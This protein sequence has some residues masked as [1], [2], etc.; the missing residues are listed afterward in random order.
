M[1]R[2][3][4]L[5]GAA[6]LPLIAAAAKFNERTAIAAEPR[7]RASVTIDPEREIGRINAWLYGQFIEQTERIVYGGVFDPGSRFADSEG[8]RTDVIDAMKKMGGA[9]ILR[10]PGGNFAS[11]YRWKDGIG[12][13]DKRPRKFDVTG[14]KYETNQFGT[15]EYLSLCQKL[16]CDRGIL[17]AGGIRAEG[18]TV[19]AVHARGCF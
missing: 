4:F 15:D 16:G 1:D 5:A 3:T 17:H 12:P 7:K 2:R 10:W 6:S 18:T 19:W 8:L 9:H 11:Y 14:K 13:R